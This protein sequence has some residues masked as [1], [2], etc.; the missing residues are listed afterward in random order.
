MKRIFELAGLKLGLAFLT[1]AFCM[2]LL[3]HLSQYP[4]Q[5]LSAVEP[6]YFSQWDIQLNG[7]V[8]TGATTS[9][10]S[11][12][13]IEITQQAE[14]A[15]VHFQLETEP[16]QFVRLQRPVVRYATIRQANQLEPSTRPVV[17]LAVEIQGQAFLLEFTLTDRSHLRYPVLLGRNAIQPGWL[18][19]IH[20]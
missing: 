20:R 7:R 15:W 5:I 4:R 3:T 16:D 17:E 18:V 19:D 14:Q 10:L 12:Q 9:S 13:Y 6:V 2:L 1:G 11:A 8:D